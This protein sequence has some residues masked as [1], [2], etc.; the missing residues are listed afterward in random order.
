MAKVI[1]LLKL[2][3]TIGDLTFRQTVWGTIAQ[4]K[5]GPTRERVLTCEKFDHTRRNAGEFRLAIKNAT[6]LRRALGEA[7][8]GSVINH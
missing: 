6:L 8:G 2:S 1:S 4:Q 3:G 7:I 5:P